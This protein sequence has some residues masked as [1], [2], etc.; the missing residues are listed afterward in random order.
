MANIFARIK[1]FNFCFS[2]KPRRRRQQERSETKGLLNRTVTWPVSFKTLYVDFLAVLCKTTTAIIFSPVSGNGNYDGN[3]CLFILEP[4]YCF[5]KLF[6][7]DKSSNFNPR[8]SSLRRC[9]LSIS[10]K[11][12]LRNFTRETYSPVKMVSI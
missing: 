6:E 11:L 9:V 4:T 3:F 1:Y 5:H 2:C 7:T 8:F 10:D 12:A